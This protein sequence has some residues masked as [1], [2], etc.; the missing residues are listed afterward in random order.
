MIGLGFPL[1][2][3]HSPLEEGRGRA[4]CTSLFRGVKN[5]S[6]PEEQD[7]SLMPLTLPAATRRAPSLSPL[8]FA[9]G[10]RVTSLFALGLI[11]P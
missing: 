1:L 4:L 2:L 8:R 6:K 3:A 5:A 10:A 9:C 7:A 11:L